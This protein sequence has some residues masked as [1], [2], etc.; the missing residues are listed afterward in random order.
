MLT[1]LIFQELLLTDTEDRF[2]IVFLKDVKY[3]D[4]ESLIKFIYKGKTEIPAANLSS[5]SN[6]AETLGKEYF[7]REIEE[8]S[9]FLLFHNFRYQ[10]FYC[11][12]HIKIT[13]EKKKYR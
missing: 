9:S 1:Q 13:S 11:K 8:I 2:P 7:F 12:S 10:R 6:L 3:S 5:C 4:L